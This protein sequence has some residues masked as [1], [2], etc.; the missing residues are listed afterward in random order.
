MGGCLDP[1]LVKGK[2]VLCN[3]NKGIAAAFAEKA[4]GSV[5]LSDYFSDISLV[6]PVSASGLNEH[7]FNIVQSY[8]NS[9]R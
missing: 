6:L 2:I 5:A 1:N 7:D 9:T 3:S 4:I 8:F